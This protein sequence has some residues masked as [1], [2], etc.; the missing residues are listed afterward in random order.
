MFSKRVLL[1]VPILL[2]LLLSA[3]LHAPSRLLA[4]SLPPALQAQAW[5][6]SL[7]SGQ[8]QGYYR[9]QSLHAAW[10]WLPS[11]LLRLQL[12]LELGLHG[13]LEAEALLLRGPFSRAVYVSLL[14]IPA[15]NAD[16]LASGTLL[17]A[18][19][20][21]DMHF[22]RKSSGEWTAGEGLLLSNGGALRLNLQGQVQEL[23]LPPASIR[24]Q[25]REGALAG[26]LRQRADNAA[27]ATL[28][29][30]A[31]NRIQW[32]VRDRLL[33]LKPGYSSQNDPDLVVLTVAEPL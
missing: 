1:A 26:E 5:G 18:W 6:G 22:A 10:R 25:V 15:G 7:L 19:Q 21:R 14:R 17:P 33:R 16:W 8:M 23:V 12:G 13:P 29:L 20:G 31:D 30:T 24:W 3:S 11:R 28:T 27:L 2:A 9:S 32:Q 4:S